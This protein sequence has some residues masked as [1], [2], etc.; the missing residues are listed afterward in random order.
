ME[1]KVQ[2]K[3]E[4]FTETEAK[5]LI[6]KKLN[7]IAFDEMSRYFSTEKKKLIAVFEKLWD[8]YKVTLE[9][10]TYEREKAVKE[11]NRFLKRLDYAQ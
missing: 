7:D 4:G 1:D 11:L 3:R 6:L 9:Q 10:I 5:K 8:K 2:K